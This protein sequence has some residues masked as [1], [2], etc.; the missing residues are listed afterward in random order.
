M[1]RETFPIVLVI[2]LNLQEKGNLHCTYSQSTELPMSWS[3]PIWED[4]FLPRP[5][6]DAQYTRLAQMLLSRQYKTRTEWRESNEGESSQKIGANL[7]PPPK[8]ERQQEDHSRLGSQ[9]EGQLAGFK[10]CNPFPMLPSLW[11]VRELFVR[12][13]KWFPWSL[14]ACGK[15][16]NGYLPVVWRFLKA[17]WSSPCQWDTKRLWHEVSGEKK[18]NPTHTHLFSPQRI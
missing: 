18:E 1:F 10:H 17:Q 11:C 9:K 12:K 13:F 8:D 3:A 15:Q 7:P 4:S 6:P 5:P 14:R 2:S 16:R